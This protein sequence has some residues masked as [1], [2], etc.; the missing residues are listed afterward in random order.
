MSRRNPQFNRQ[1]LEVELPKRGIRY[2]WEGE[3]LGGFRKGG[4][5]AYM[6]T[7]SFATGLNRLER[8]LDAGPTAIMCAEIV[9]FRCHR[10]FIA[11]QMARRGYRV[12]HIVQR[13]KPGYDEPLPSDTQ[14][15]TI[16]E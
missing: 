2:V 6:R 11:R 10:R 5:D 7:D 4:Y 15:H 14:P 16:P 3:A 8:L 13:G 9:W 1:T 12:T